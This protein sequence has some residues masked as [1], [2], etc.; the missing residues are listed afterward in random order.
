MEINEL[1]VYLAM[2]ENYRLSV[3]NAK[4]DLVIATSRI[5]QE[6]RRISVIAQ[7]VINKIIFLVNL[8]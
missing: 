7:R 6:F 4:Y 2:S 5:F 1:S 8:K 3:K